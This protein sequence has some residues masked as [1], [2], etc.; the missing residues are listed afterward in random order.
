MKKRISVA[1]T[2]VLILFA[3][4]LTF[5]ITYNFIEKQYQKK[6]DALTKNQSDFSV[7]AEADVLIRENFIG[8]VNEDA[9]DNG[10]IKGY[11]SSLSDPYARFL[12]KEEYQI[13]L[14]EKKGSGIGIGA[15]FTYQHDNG[16]IRER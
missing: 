9:L 4:L 3:V 7:L 13:Y 14:E 8:A 11:L 6:V 1:T 5:Q 15:R 2:F 16:E 12:T 10:L